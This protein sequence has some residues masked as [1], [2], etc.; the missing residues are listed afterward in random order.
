MQLVTLPEARSCVAELEEGEWFAALLIG[1]GTLDGFAVG[2][3]ILDSGRITLAEL[4]T[5]VVK[6]PPNGPDRLLLGWAEKGNR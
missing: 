4:R 3:V 2:C 6:F 1:I 5:I